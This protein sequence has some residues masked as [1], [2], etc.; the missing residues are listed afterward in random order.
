MIILSH[1]T[2]EIFCTILTN[3]RK[4]DT[5]GIDSRPALLSRNQFTHKIFAVSIVSFAKKVHLG[6]KVFSSQVS[7]CY[8]IT[9][10]KLLFRGMM[11]V[12]LRKDSNVKN[13]LSGGQKQQDRPVTNMR[14]QS[15]FVSALT[16]VTWT[17]L[18]TV[19]LQA[20]PVQGQIGVTICA[21]QPS[22]Y[23]F[24]LNFSLTCSQKTVVGPG[25]VSSAC[26]VDTELA[27]NVTD[28]TPVRVTTI[29]ILELNQNL[30]VIAQTFLN[31]NYGSG[32]T[33]RYVSVTVSPNTTSA[34]QISKGIQISLAGTNQ[35]DQALVNF[36]LILFTNDC[37]I[38]PV[39][40]QGQEIG[41][42]IFVS[43]S[44]RNDFVALAN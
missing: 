26:T 13:R 42:T 14:K 43:L 30:D 15:S 9:M 10:E 2:N 11:Q 3:Y 6:R 24:K 1:V 34:L 37:G 20:V 36:W 32:D 27:Q 8:S 44:Q 18:L 12:N 40:L 22:V 25:I 29:Q 5:N 21:C 17:L 41:W 19:A 33:F 35:F 4:F 16:N 39:I 31:G 23:E 38:Y 28:F 7:K